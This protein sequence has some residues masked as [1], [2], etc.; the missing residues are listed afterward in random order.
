MTGLE[1]TTRQENYVSAIAGE[2]E[3]PEGMVPVTREEIYLNAILEAIANISTPTQE[4]I[5]VAVTN[6]F[7]EQGIDALFIDSADIPEVL[8]G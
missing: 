4:Q 7:E 2:S 8:E 3:L 6:Y 1:P 5:N